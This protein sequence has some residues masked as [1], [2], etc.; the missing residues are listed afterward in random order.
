MQKKISTSKELPA[1]LSEVNLLF[2]KNCNI[3]IKDYRIEPE[4]ED[5]NAASLTLDKKQVLFRLAK[6]TPKK[7]GMFV[8]LWKRNKNGI[9]TPYHK[10]DNV[11]LVIIEVRKSDRIGHFVFNKNILVEK[12]IITSNKEGK[13]GFRIYPPWELASSKQAVSSQVWQSR[14]FFEHQK[15]N[16]EDRL[17][18]KESLLKFLR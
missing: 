16:Q 6:I 18:L 2:S 10:K 1:I 9:T 15:V 3:E 8:T 5:Y 13:R 12:G 7:I 14:Y 17:R 4:S 11:D